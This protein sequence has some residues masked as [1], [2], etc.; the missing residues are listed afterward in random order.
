MST[1]IYSGF[2]TI[3][4][5]PMTLT[6]L[7]QWCDNL[8]K[9]SKQYLLQSCEKIFMNIIREYLISMKFSEYV[10]NSTLSCGMLDNKKFSELLKDFNQD[11]LNL[12]YNI[13]VTIRDENRL[14]WSEGI[15]NPFYDLTA[16]IDLYLHNGRVYGFINDE[17]GLYDYLIDIG[18][19]L[20]YHYQNQTDQPENISDEE[21]KE[22]AKVWNK[23]DL[24]NSVEIRIDWRDVLFSFTISSQDVYKKLLE[25]KEIKLDRF[26]NYFCY[27]SSKIEENGYTYAR[28]SK[29]VQENIKEF[30]KDFDIAEFF[31]EKFMKD[32]KQLSMN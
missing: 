24:N 25:N 21:W 1:K 7:F 11:F 30:F 14:I 15:R 32:D 22:R 27:D 8:K 31:K 29:E 16:I 3:S 19:I 17:R 13:I 28:L 18:E 2:T 4:N 6:E 23:I 12:F 20:D 26:L 9:F 5:K 10:G